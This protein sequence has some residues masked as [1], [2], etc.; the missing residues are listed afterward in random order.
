[1]KKSQKTMMEHSEVKIKL[2]ETY[3]KKYLQI[4]SLS[5]YTD[6]IYLYDLFSGEGIYENG[7]K[8][9]PIIFLETIKNTYFIN[10]GKNIGK[11]NCHF[12]DLDKNKI[13]KLKNIVEREKLHYS[14]IGELNFTTEDYND[15][16]KSVVNEVN[17][18]KNE[19]AF[20]FIDPYGYKDI[21]IKD[22]SQL[23][24]SNK[25]EVLL[26]LPTQFMFRFE[27]KGSP[28]CLLEFINEIVPIDEWPK[29]ETGIDFIEKLTEAFRNLLPNYFI[30]SFIITRELNQFF[31]LFF[32]T[33]HIYG[34][35]RMLESKWELDEQE[36]RGWQ[37]NSEN[38]LFSLL[39]DKANTHKFESKLKDFLKVDRTNG[40]IYKFTLKHGHLVTHANDILKKFQNEVGLIVNSKDGSRPRKSA[41]YIGWEN[42]KKNPDKIKIKIE[43]CQNQV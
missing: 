1:M 10:K 8:G 33:S 22:I 41:F 24:K 43:S 7:G 16:L 23:L 36:G 12:N 34:F 13:E 14:S 11:F 27:K 35:D 3:L 5:P 42:Y 4:L 29:S 31:C 28:V 19:K 40:D 17:Q 21:R 32:F 18:F 26:F 37:I 25:S 15:I 20:V 2:L 30:D 38:N 6:D 39:E 9:S